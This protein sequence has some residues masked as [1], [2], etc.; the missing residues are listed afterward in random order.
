MLNHTRRWDLRC[1]DR[2]HE[3]MVRLL[4]VLASSLPILTLSPEDILGTVDRGPS[5]WSTLTN[6]PKPNILGVSRNEATVII[7]HPHG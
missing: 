7:R 3:D 1:N 2:G 4:E 5:V 6:K